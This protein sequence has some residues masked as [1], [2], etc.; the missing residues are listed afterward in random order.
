[1]EAH[2]IVNLKFT[3]Y[4]ISAMEARIIVNKK[5][6]NCIKFI[7]GKTGWVIPDYYDAETS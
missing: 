3:Y 6:T 1:M 5:F 4:I 7:V 2:I